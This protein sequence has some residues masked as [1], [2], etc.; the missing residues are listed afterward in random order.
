V[1]FFSTIELVNALEKEQAQGK[2]GQIALRLTYADLVILDELGYLPFTLRRRAAVPPDQQALRA[3]QPRHHHQPGLLRMGQVFGDAKMTTALLDRITHHC[4][5]VETGNDSWRLRNSTA[6]N[7]QSQNQGKG[8]HHPPPTD[9][10]SPVHR[11]VKVQRA[12]WVS[13]K[14][15]PTDVGSGGAVVAGAPLATPHPTAIP[16]ATSVAGARMFSK[17]YSWRGSPLSPRSG[18]SVGRRGCRAAL[19]VDQTHARLQHRRVH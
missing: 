7:K 8:G 16:A 13:F 6:A 18:C 5:I 3:H 1:R 19:Q 15:A 17:R 14:C 10:L 4:H 2:A 12:A 9:T 11:W